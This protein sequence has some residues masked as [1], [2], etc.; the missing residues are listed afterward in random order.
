MCSPPPSTHIVSTAPPYF[1]QPP[2]FAHSFSYS[3]ISA[4]RHNTTIHSPYHPL[5]SVH[6]FSVH[7]SP[8]AASLHLIHPPN[9]LTSSCPPFSTPTTHAASQPHS[10]HSF[11]AANSPAPFSS[12]PIQSDNPPAAPPFSFKSTAPSLFLTPLSVA[13][14]TPD[15]Q[16]PSSLPAFF[17][18]TP[19]RLLPHR[20]S[21]PP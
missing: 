4:H 6:S 16:H 9:P 8:P 13:N 21:A 10:L 12:P 15:H 3:I 7:R 19:H 11:F 2:P 17:F 18:N 14:N 1:H 5:L 20:R